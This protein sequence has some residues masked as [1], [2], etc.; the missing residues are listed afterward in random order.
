[1]LIRC[2]DDLGQLSILSAERRFRIEEILSD[3]HGT[4]V[5]QH[6]EPGVEVVRHQDG[7]FEVTILF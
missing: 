4:A 2:P 6:S 5:T 1:M 7:C 3:M